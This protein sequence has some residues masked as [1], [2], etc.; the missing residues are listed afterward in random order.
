MNRRE[1][2]IR[3]T[4]IL[5]L[6]GIEHTK[7]TYRFGGRDFLLTDVHGNVVDGLLAWSR[8]I[9]EPRKTRKGY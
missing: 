1:F 8:R 5:H 6:M 9:N 2:I 4:T 7:L 3:A